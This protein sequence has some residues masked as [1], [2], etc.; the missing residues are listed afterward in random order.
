MDEVHPG[1]RSRPGT[2]NSLYM[3]SRNITLK[4]PPRDGIRKE[5]YRRAYF[6]GAATSTRKRTI[7]PAVNLAVARD[8]FGHYSPIGPRAKRGVPGRAATAGRVTTSG[9]HTGPPVR[10]G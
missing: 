2:S 8:R 1:R 4:S 10:I 5:V 6:S 9:R 7:K 3:I